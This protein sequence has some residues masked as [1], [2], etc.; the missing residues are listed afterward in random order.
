[1]N[2][3]R[4]AGRLA[5]VPLLV[6][7]VTG[8]GGKSQQISEDDKPGLK[9]T[10]PPAEAPAPPERK[11][12]AIDEALQKRAMK[13]LLLQAGPS[14]SA[15]LRAHAIEALKDLN[16]R[17]GEAI[18]L[19]G[20]SDRQGLV[21]F[22]AAMAAGENHLSQAKPILL[23]ML[24]DPSTPVQIAVRFALHKLGDYSHS[25]DLEVYV[26]SD[27][28][29]VRSNAVVVLGLLEE[30]SA[31]KILVPM[32][33][34]PDPVVRLQVA[35]AL[36]RLHD[37]TGLKALIALSLSQ[38]AYDQTVAFLALAG[39]RDIR[40]VE[41]IRTGLTN[42][43]VEVRLVAARAMGMLG[44]DDGYTVAQHELTS[45]DARQRH[46]AALALGEI[47]RTDAQPLLA[48]LLDDADAAVRVAAAKA[49]LQLGKTVSQ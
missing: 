6:A 8:C 1:M 34:D 5:F 2:N 3:I 35:E 13:E 11:D 14:N 20:L 22:A 10:K 46:L 24:E 38:Q 48:P 29:R 28:K 9:W 33:R 18:I 45:K 49:I 27:D 47:G 25:H 23:T 37:E 42:D 26:Q 16:L 21:R 19:D 7:A 32:L 30:P 31:R 17:E 41:H 39:P 12:I 40:V 44:L 15:I 36:W 4:L 43:Y